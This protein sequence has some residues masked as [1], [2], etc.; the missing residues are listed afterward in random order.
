MAGAGHFGGDVDH[1]CGHFLRGQRGL[2][3][4]GVVHAV[5]QRQHQRAGQEVRADGGSG[6]FG[7]GGLDAEQHQRGTGH[8]A[9]FCAGLQAHLFLEALCVEQQTVALDGVHMVRPADQ[10][11]VMAR[12]RQHAAVITTDCTG[13]HDCNF[14]HFFS[15]VESFYVAGSRATSAASVSPTGCATL[16]VNRSSARVRPRFTAAMGLPAAA[17]ACTKR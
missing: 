15:L 6:A 11:D 12:T 3:A 5:L 1:G 4:H 8:G 2:Q 16:R 10:G 14:C 7:V 13:T 17:A 9:R